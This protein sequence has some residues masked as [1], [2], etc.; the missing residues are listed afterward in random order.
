MKSLLLDRFFGE[1]RAA[2]LKVFDV[3]LVTAENCR[4]KGVESCALFCTF[5]FVAVDV[6]AISAR[7]FK[8]LNSGEHV[9]SS[10]GE[11]VSEQ[12]GPMEM[13]AHLFT[14]CQSELCKTHQKLISSLKYWDI[15]SCGP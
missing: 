11:L 2:D 10:R 8:S 12:G 9:G 13:I 1:I 14:N 5:F 3:D 4:L 7:A 6:F 15:R